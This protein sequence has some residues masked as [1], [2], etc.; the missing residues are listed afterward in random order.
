MI[1]PEVLAAMQA[2]VDAEGEK[3]EAALLAHVQAY[4]AKQTLGRSSCPHGCM[5]CGRQN[6]ECH[7][8]VVCRSAH[9]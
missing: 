4:E 8:C 6:V 1:P 3:Y 5:A 9:G 2:D 7:Q